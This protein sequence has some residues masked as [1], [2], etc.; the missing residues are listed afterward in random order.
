MQATAMQRCLADISSSLAKA[1]E[2][3]FTPLRNFVYFIH[4]ACQDKFMKADIGA[5]LAGFSLAPPRVGGLFGSKGRLPEALY[6][7]LPA[8][9]FLP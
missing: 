1:P 6:S 8:D 9:D 5:K 7:P 2:Q 3:T 4:F